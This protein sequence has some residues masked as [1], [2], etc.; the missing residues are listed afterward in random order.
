MTTSINIL[1][2]PKGHGE[3]D[4]LISE[5]FTRLERGGWL[6]GEWAVVDDRLTINPAVIPSPETIVMRALLVRK[7]NGT[8]NKQMRRE[9]RHLHRELLSTPEAEWRRNGDVHYFLE[10]CYLSGSDSAAVRENRKAFI[11]RFERKRL[12]A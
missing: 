4:C 11:E 1:A 9:W 12:C 3:L 2:Q 5:A 10:D 8:L 6:V 7:L